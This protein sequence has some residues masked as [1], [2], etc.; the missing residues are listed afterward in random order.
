MTRFRIVRARAAAAI[1]VV[2]IL[3]TVC[4][5]NGQEVQ[6][7]IIDLYGVRQI[8]AGD[9]RGALT[10][11]EGDTI[12]RGD[13]QRPSF[14]SASE[15]RVARLPGVTSARLRIVCCDEG[16]AIVYVG[17]EERGAAVMRLRAAPMGTSRIWCKG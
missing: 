13:G 11:K 7:G 6:I 12:S 3:A 5:V 9:V 17:V 8:S 2:H 1:F 16:R 15:D 14:L 4:N 10:F